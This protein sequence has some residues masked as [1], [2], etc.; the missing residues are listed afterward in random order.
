VFVTRATR[1]DLDQVRA[2]YNDLDWFGD[3][4]EPDLS[5]GVT[6]MARR[7]LIIGAARLLELGPQVLALE[8]VLVHP[9]HRGKGVGAQ[10]I[11]AAM[12]SRGGSFFLSCHDDVLA[13]YE[14]FG[15]SV[16]SFDDLPNEAQSFM[17]QQGQW[18]DSPE[19]RHYFMRAR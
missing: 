4:E 17:E 13:Y 9:D 6:F 7:G 10:L 5:H 18:P 8:D 15:F 14:R 1:R 3:G 16:L 11:R 19:H 2:F 12:N